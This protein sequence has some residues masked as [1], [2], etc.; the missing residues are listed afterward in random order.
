[1][2]VAEAN[3]ERTP[4]PANASYGLF[5]TTHWSVVLSA[6][7]ITSPHSHEALARLC[8]VYRSPIFSFAL[9][10]GFSHA[11]GEDLTQGFFAH[12][13]KNN[14]AG[15]AERREGIKFRTFLLR[16]FKNF[17][18]DERDRGSAKK[19]GGDQ[20]TTSLDEPSGEGQVR[21]EPANEM[22]ADKIYER[23][24][25]TALLNHVL[26]RLEGE[27]TSRGRKA[28]FARLHVSLLDRKTA[29]SYAET[30]GLLGL[31]E[32]AVKKEV[33][34]MRQRYRQLLREE[35]AHTVRNPDEIEE[36]LQHLFVVIS[37]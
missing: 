28:V 11:D 25:A 15:K 31:A 20:V 12:F 9:G 1:L 5:A 6:G 32:D 36:E 13:L 18:A 37:G 24:W 4:V 30:A 8:E 2:T 35:I 16:C 7:Q 17:L 10:L 27:Y 3:E 19:R 23:D 26:D 33:S 29:T 34:R 14:L 21:W 22:T